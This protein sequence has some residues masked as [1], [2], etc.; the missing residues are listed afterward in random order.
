LMGVRSGG[1]H[2]INRFDGVSQAW[3]WRLRTAMNR[4]DL[5]S[6]GESSG[7]AFIAVGT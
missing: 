2:G 7:A 5:S 6:A 4:L 1:I 3:K